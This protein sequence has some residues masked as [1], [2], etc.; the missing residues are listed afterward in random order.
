MGNCLGVASRRHM[1]WTQNLRVLF[2]GT[3]GVSCAAIH[4]GGVKN[5]PVGWCL[6]VS[7]EGINCY[8]WRGWCADAGE[9]SL[10][11]LCKG[12][13]RGLGQSLQKDIACPVPPVPQHEPRQPLSPDPP[14]P[15]PHPRSVQGWIHKG[16]Q[17]T[18]LKR[19]KIKLMV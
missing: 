15:V 12:T 6:W 10:E 9:P 14:P 11:T 7:P 8:R 18:E 3:E 1:G 2:L 4:K 13:R 5:G 16:L 19:A 17:L